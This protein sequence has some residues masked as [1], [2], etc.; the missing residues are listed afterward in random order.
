MRDVR[1]GLMEAACSVAYGSEH[2]LSCL[3]ILS[4]ES[5]QTAAAGPR[6]PVLAMN[7]S[8]SSNVLSFLLRREQRLAS[9]NG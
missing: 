7:A 9:A 8:R 3:T 1:D 6:A 4:I 5:P 2:E